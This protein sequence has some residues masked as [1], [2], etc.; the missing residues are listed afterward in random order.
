M[1]D[2]EKKR[3]AVRDEE[4]EYNDET[5][6]RLAIIA[7]FVLLLA[8]IAGAVYIALTSPPSKPNPEPPTPHMSPLPFTTRI[9]GVSE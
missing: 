5:R 9:R 8:M 1:S 2:D 4:R 7:L 3:R 6:A